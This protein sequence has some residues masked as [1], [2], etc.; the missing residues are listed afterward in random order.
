MDDF[1][2]K[3][4]RGEHFNHFIVALQ[5]KKMYVYWSKK[6][7]LLHH[8]TVG[9][10]KQ[11]IKYFSAGICMTDRKMQASQTNETTEQTTTSGKNISQA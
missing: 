11:N 4:V 7:I 5:D 6:R 8:I 9:L 1:E 10:Q 2:I 3:Y